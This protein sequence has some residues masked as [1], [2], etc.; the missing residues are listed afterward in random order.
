MTDPLRPGVVFDVDGTLLDTNY[1]HV[2]A[3]T[4]ALRAHGYDHVTMEQVHG[5]IGIASGE[6]VEH[7]TGGRDDETAEAHTKFYEP[8][9]DDIRAFPDAPELMRA[10][11]DAGLR[12][13]IA[14]SGKEKDLEW[15]LPAIGVDSDLIDGSSTSSDVDSAKPAPEL[16]EVAMEKSGL[17]PERTVAL[18]D[19]IWDVQA[20]QRA[21]IRC[22]AL[23]CG[24]IGEAELREA[25]AVE[26]WADPA[27]L[28]AHLDESILPALA[29]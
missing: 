16:L 27:D 13:V 19:T 6:L 12:V 5:A 14:T 1:L 23:T 15:M 3:W 9:Q 18:G 2:V 28:L 24:G 26:V 8:F 29:A 10:C 21:G 17:D 7:L 25:G 4:R 22:I 20:A 11:S